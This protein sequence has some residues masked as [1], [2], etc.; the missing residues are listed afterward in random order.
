VADGGMGVCLYATK[1]KGG[2]ALLF[3]EHE[4]IDLLYVGLLDL[5]TEFHVFLP[6]ISAVWR[7]AL[8]DI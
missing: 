8:L 5:A 2:M 1:N 4:G 7:R 3:F 6:K